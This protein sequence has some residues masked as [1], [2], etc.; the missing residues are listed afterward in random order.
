MFISCEKL[1][2]SAFEL[3]FYVHLPTNYEPLSS[4]VSLWNLEP[5]SVN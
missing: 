2:Q 4:Q 3:E 5:F 1:S